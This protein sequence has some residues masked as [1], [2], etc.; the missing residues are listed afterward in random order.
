MTGI[1]IVGLAALF[2]I[3]AGMTVAATYVYFGHYHY[4]WR[5]W[6]DDD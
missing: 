3:A 2:L 6:S 4:R 5:N 1:E